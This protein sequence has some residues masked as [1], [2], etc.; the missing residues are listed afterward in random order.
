MRTLSIVLVMGLLGAC[1]RESTSKSEPAAKAEPEPEPG[2]EFPRNAKAFE[3]ELAAIDEQIA[4][5]EARAAKQP[6]SWMA[7]EQVANLWLRRARLSGNYDDYAKAED[8]L[9]RAFATAPANAGPFL[10]RAALNF[11]LHRLDAV[12]PDL[13]K[14]ASQPLLDD[15]IRA[16]VESMRGDLAFER[17]Q[18]PAARTHF[19][20]ALALDRTPSILA[21][22]ALWHLRM[23]EFEQAE[24]LYLDAEAMMIGPALE[25]HAWT[26]LQLGI[27]DLERGRYEEAFEHYRSGA[28]QLG[29]WWL[30]EEHIA[31]I[32]VLL[33]MPK[34]A[35]A[36]YDEIIARTGKP[37][38]I[39][40]KAALLAE[41]GDAEG[42]A[43][44]VEQA[45]GIYEAELKRFPEASY[46]HAL[47]HYLEFGPPARALELAEANHRLR[48]HVE[49]KL[50]LAQARLGV[51]DVAGAKAIVDEALA[52]DYI[53]ADLFW[54][55]SQVYAAHG[56]TSQA[57]TLREQAQGLNPH[58][59]D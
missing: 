22:L 33:G 9:A 20:A 13:D 58:I 30:I 28:A 24:R 52:T 6:G 5:V 8:A 53:S 15:N 10:T 23:G 40:A 42:S 34:F 4:K 50:G 17:G 29:G 26:H 3:A 35:T 43:A 57:A 38:F 1:N 54:V 36:L 44:L 18:Y 48:P 49:A 2:L 19:D 46:G 27:M 39:D 31:E 59:A 12:G 16:V 25:P 47:D 32:A 45:T 56:D 55:A 21:K 37:E 11:T 51:G 14:V 7:L 41:A